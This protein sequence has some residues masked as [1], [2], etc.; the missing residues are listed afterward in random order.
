MKLAYCLLLLQAPP[1]LLLLVVVLHLAP[2]PELLVCLSQLLLLPA[3]PLS[4]AAPVHWLLLL[5]L[6]CLHGQHLAQ[7]HHAAGNQQR[8]Q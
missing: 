4:A 1:Q 6:W 8:Q 2:L 3:V 5:L 7:R